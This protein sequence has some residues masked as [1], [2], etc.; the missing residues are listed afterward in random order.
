MILK[1]GES[2][3]TVSEETG[4]SRR[5]VAIRP[6]PGHRLEEYSENAGTDHA[7]T[8]IRKRF[9][10]APG[11]NHWQTLFRPGRPLPEKSRA[12]GPCRTDR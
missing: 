9:E 2:E 10:S 7:C 6:G 8:I 4:L 12:Y 5:Q 1:S 11:C 3:L